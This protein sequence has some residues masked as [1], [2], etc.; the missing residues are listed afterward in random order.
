MRS[1]VKVM[2]LKIDIK[3]TNSKLYSC[4]SLKNKFIVVKKHKKAYQIMK[5]TYTFNI[6]LIIKKNMPSEK[7]NSFKNTYYFKLT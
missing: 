4:K 2:K 6:T 3:R 5:L 7:K 1:K